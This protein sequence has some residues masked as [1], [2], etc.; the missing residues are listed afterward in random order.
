MEYFIELCVILLM[1]KLNSMFY[2]FYWNWKF[3]NS[4]MIILVIRELKDYLVLLKIG[5]I[6]LECLVRL[7]NI[8]RIV[9]VVV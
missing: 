7:K 1:E 5:V 3:L 4:V 9:N 2:Y 8:V 6:G